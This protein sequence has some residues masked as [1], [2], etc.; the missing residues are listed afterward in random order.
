[1]K[2]YNNIDEFFKEQV[3]G[4]KVTP[5]DK[6]WDNIES[7]YFTSTRKGNRHLKIWALVS[8][9]LI[10]GSIITWKMFNKQVEQKNLITNSI[11]GIESTNLGNRTEKNDKINASDNPASNSSIDVSNNIIINNSQTPK[12]EEHTSITAESGTPS[13]QNNT[14]QNNILLV[15]EKEDESVSETSD[16]TSADPVIYPSLYAEL[17]V[18]SPF[19]L[20]RLS[21]RNTSH[22]EN[23]VSTS[24][25]E[26]FEIKTIDEYLEKRRNLH[27]YTGASASIAMVYY[28]ATTDQSSW[29]AD[30]V[31]GIKLKQ[32]YIETGI[33]YQR[34]KEQGNFQIDYKT[35]DSIGF[36]NKVISF[37]LH[38]DD[39][40]VI[41]Y[42]IAT[43]TVFDSV[44]HH[45]LQSPLYHYDYITLPIKFGYKFYQKTKLTISAETGIIYSILNATHAP[46][47]D[48]NDPESQLLGIT[49]NTPARIDHNF[50]IHIALRLNYNIAKTVSLNLQPEFSSYLNSINEKQRSNNKPYTMGIRFGICFDF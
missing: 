11:S 31:Y 37:E 1:M 49:D 45:L 40:S 9:L 32:F 12:T 23:S 50:R 15:K 28:S 36:Y 47:V 18:S 16:Q 4:Y 10:T 7:D 33:G 6:V 41:A 22:I 48:Y 35:N 42:K 3:S 13:S 38:P 19:Q 5:S 39:P 29:S 8:L 14:T 21:Q 25:L 24:I 17:N 44:E 30:L 20:S 26:N 2:K 46:K 43:T 34:M 27:F